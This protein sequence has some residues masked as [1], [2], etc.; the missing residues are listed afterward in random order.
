V[1]RLGRRDRRLD[2]LEIA[3]LTYK[4]HVGILAQGGAQ[5][6]AE[7]AGVMSYFALMN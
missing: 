1:A 4:D 7:T 6:I 2:R 5:S 3:K